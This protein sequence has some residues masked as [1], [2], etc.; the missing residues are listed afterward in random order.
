M[1]S[2]LYNPFSFMLSSSVLNFSFNVYM[3]QFFGKI[4][5]FSGFKI[6]CRFYYAK[7]NRIATFAH[8]LN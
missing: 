4:M 6:E 7:R 1:R 2:V 8:L 5:D 3:V